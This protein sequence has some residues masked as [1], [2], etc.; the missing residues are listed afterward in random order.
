[1][2]AP[3]SALLTGHNILVTGAARGIGLA[4]AQALQA[5]GARVILG[6]IDGGICE[7]EAAA[8]PGAIG[9]KLDVTNPRSIAKAVQQIEVSVGVLDGLVNNAAVLNESHATSVSMDEMDKIMAVNG[10][11]VLRLSQA[12]LPFLQLSKHASIVN[13]LSTQSFYAQ[14]NGIAYGA[15][16]GAALALTRCMA[17]D[18][19]P[20]SIR[21]NGVA[22]GFI[23]TRMALMPDG[24]HEHKT[25]LFND[26]YVSACKIP[27]G[28]GGKPEECAGAFV[29][30]LSNL[31]SYVTG[32]VITVD[33]GLTA[34]Y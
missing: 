15:A 19:A 17:V 24:Q 3:A 25:S 16:K 28:R 33:G 29:Y 23:D 10:T 2:T 12:M 14:P 34:T 11:S 13:T 32:Q 4:T 22:P 20:L 26:F 1:M 9:L 21:V 18:F 7:Q 30:L 5:H 27:M 6:D 8:L 31:S